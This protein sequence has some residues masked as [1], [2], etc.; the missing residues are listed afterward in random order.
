MTRQHA[1]S[2]ARAYFSSGSLY[3]S[4]ASKIA[5]PSES[6]EP[7]RFHE[8]E[9]YLTEQIIPD[10]ERLGFEWEIIENP[11]TGYGPFL[12]AERSEPEAGLTVL[13]YGHGDVIRGYDDQ[14]AE[15]LSPWKMT[16]RGDRWY[17]R[18]TADNKGQHTI[19]LAALESVLAATD[20]KLGYNV[21]LILEMGEETGSPGLNEICQRYQQRLAADVFIGSDG[22]R[23]DAESPTV[24]LGSRGS[25]NFDL[26]LNAREGAHHS[27]NWGGVLKN[28]AVRLANALASM[29]TPQGVI[30]VKGLRPEPIPESVRHAIANLTIGNGD[31][32]PAI[33][34]TWGEPGLTPAERLFA[35]NTLEIL[36]LKAG[37]PDAPVNAIPPTAYA[38]CQLRYVVGSDQDK[39]IEHLRGHLDAHGYQDIDVTPARMSQMKATRL[40]PDD[41]WVSWALASIQTTTGKSPTLLPNLGGS[42]PNDVF[43]GT[44]GLPTLWIPHSYP[45][46]SQ[47]APDEH[48]LESLA[49]EALYLMTGLFW[50]LGKQGA[51][52][53]KERK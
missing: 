21:K 27:G 43:A 48:M 34:P 29:V 15:G 30:Q 6:Q 53:V 38:H 50:D 4:L 19:N 2:K 39:F 49:E 23:L 46:C 9:R 22:P 32:A 25:F 51:D 37:N 18:G 35:W 10:L 17:G 44:L 41:P 3:R 8:L 1:I 11:V 40:D 45:S 36:A 42:L 16:Q 7:S 52:I 13:S 5:I 14:W 31:N 20:G 28:P 12:L 26:T 33:D 47:H 24:F